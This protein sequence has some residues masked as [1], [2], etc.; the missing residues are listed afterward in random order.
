[1]IEPA[2]LVVAPYVPVPADFGGAVRMLHLVQAMARH[3]HVILLAPATPVDFTHLN[4][5]AAIA[6]VTLVPVRW[7]AR[8]H[9]GPRKRILQ[10]RSLVNRRSYLE[11]ATANTTIQRIVDRLFLTRNIELIHYE[12]TQMALF[13]PTTPRP[14]VIDAHNVEHELLRRV[15]RESTSPIT[16]PLKSI[17]ARKLRSFERRLWQDADLVVATSERDAAGIHANGARETCVVPNGVDT[18]AFTRPPAFHRHATDIV[19]SGALRHEPNAEGIRWYLDHVHPRVVHALPDAR[20]SIVGADPPDW[21][22]KRASPGITITGRVDDIRPNLWGARCSIVPIHA[23]GG[24]RLKIVE[25][26]AAGTPVVSTSLGAEGIEATPSRDLLIADDPESFARQIVQV[27][28]D[29]PLAE[30][31]RDNAA[32][33]VR[34]R[35]DW[36]VIAPRLLDAHERARGRF[37]TRGSETGTGG[38]E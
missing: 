34:S 3:Q 24:T 25:A 16:G 8:H 15:A 33:L 6:D 30:S 9:S 20:L 12:F 4:D 38:A 21:L 17:E 7:T 19:F 23:G 31:L 11:M 10:L 2:I 26:F 27:L 5:L 29:N 35:Y 37:S 1:M 14:T 22:A 32:Q 13:R 36:S 18:E 28:V